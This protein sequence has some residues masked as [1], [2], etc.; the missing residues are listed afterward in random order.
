MARNTTLQNLIKMVREEAGHSTN[1]AIGQADTDSIAARIRRTQKR[2]YYDYW[3]PHL[4]ADVTEALQ[5]GERYYGYN[6]GISP[7]RIHAVYVEDVGN[8]CRIEHGIDPGHYN[9]VDSEA[10]ER[11]DPVQ[12]W[13]LLTD[14]TYE[15][16]PIPATAGQLR[17]IGLQPLPRLTQMSDRAVLD[18]DLLALY[19]SAELLMR[20]K[21]PDAEYK[22]GLADQHY[23]RLRAANQHNDMFVLGGGRK[24]DER[25]ASQAARYAYAPRME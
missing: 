18:D 4:R 16:W 14:D 23:R 13:Q 8:W 3:W 5:V 7:D 17:F 10:D 15:V 25:L 24:R 21:S 22:M 19:V 11:R 12:R 20:Q 1:P 6:S 9:A 2:L